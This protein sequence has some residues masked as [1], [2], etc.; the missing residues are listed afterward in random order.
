MLVNFLFRI[1]NLIIF[2]GTYRLHRLRGERDCP[3]NL[4]VVSFIQ[5]NLGA[6]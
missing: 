1:A 6:T 3:A 5:V 2:Y 4:K